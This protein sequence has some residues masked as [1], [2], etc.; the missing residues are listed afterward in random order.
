[1]SEKISIEIPKISLNE[2]DIKSL[3]NFSSQYSKNDWEKLC[4]N[5]QFMNG[6]L[7]KKLADSQMLA[8]E[9]L[10]INRNNGN[11]S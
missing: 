6:V 11:P 1:M 10:G 9:I 8:D 3:K 4:S 7:E 5:K 2:P